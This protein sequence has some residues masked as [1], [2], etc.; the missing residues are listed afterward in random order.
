MTKHF[1]VC[2]C[3]KRW[4]CILNILPLPNGLG[5]IR[6]EKW[7]DSICPECIEG[8]L[9]AARDQAEAVAILQSMMQ[10]GDALLAVEAKKR[11]TAV[12]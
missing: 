6:C 11:L 1:H 7:Q 2:L 9:E 4:P 8:C 10:A 12:T 5:R 3:Q